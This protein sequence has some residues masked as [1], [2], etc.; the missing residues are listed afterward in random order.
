MSLKNETR[1]LETD[2]FA[3]L[4]MEIDNAD[5]TATERF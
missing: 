4:G 1:Q 2:A 5:G 3:N